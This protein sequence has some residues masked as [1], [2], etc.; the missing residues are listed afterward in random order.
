ME[1]C[2][3][4]SQWDPIRVCARKIKC[5]WMHLLKMLLSCINAVGCVKERHAPRCMHKM[6]A[7]LSVFGCAQEILFKHGCIYYLATSSRWISVFYGISFGGFIDPLEWYF[8]FMPSSIF[9][10]VICYIKNTGYFWRITGHP[11]FAN[12][13]N[14]TYPNLT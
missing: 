3:N 11:K 10:K 1:I 9:F 7:I 13:S 6:K 8:I 12:K 4:N 5:S 14:L 2:N